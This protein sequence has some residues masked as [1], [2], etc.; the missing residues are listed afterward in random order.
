[1]QHKLAAFDKLR[2]ASLRGNRRLSK[3]IAYKLSL[4]SKLVG[5]AWSL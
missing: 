1:M 4:R 5:I 3:D 2:E